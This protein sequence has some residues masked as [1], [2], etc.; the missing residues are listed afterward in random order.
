LRG[1]LGL[2]RPCGAQDVCLP[3][4]GP[5]GE[6]DFSVGLRG[7]GRLGSK[8]ARLR[9]EACPVLVARSCGA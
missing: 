3:E 8:E 5:R 4:V 1:S 6:F 7:D 2:V 9:G